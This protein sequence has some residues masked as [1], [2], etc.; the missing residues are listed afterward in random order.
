MNN[1][2][3]NNLNIM[4]FNSFNNYQNNNI[5]NLN[6]MI[7]NNV[8]NYNPNNQNINKV[9]ESIDKNKILKILKKAQFKLSGFKFSKLKPTDPNSKEEGNR[10]GTP[11]Y[12]APELYLMETSLRVIEDQKVDIWAFGVLA[13]EMFFGRRPFEAD[14]I[15]QLSRMY[16]IGEYYLNFKEP[17]YRKISKEFFEFLNLCL[18]QNP[19]VRANAN[20]L[21]ILDFYNRDFNECTFLD[22]KELFDSLQ[23]AEKDEK[24]K[25]IIIFYKN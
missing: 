1:P 11:L 15:D 14:S 21:R 9:K 6:Y 17:I 3:N 12:M 13:F 20:D 23:S 4:N 18:Q 22:E 19:K 5:F 10:C 7:M 2:F 8:N 16:K 24:N 25:I